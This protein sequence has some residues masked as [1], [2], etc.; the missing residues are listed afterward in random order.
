ML[1]S[2]EIAARL[3][4]VGRRSASVFSVAPAVLV[5]IVEGLLRGGQCRR[6]LLQGVP[7]LLL[8]RR[9]GGQQVGGRADGGIQRLALVRREPV[10]HRLHL[11]DDLAEQ[12]V[13]PA[14][15]RGERRRVT[16]GRLELAHDVLDVLATAR[17]AAAE[18]AQ[19]GRQT[20]R[21]RVVQGLDDVLVVLGEAGLLHRHPLAR[22]QD[23]RR[24]RAGEQVD[25]LLADERELADRRRGVDVQRQRLLLEVHR[26]QGDLAVRVDRRGAGGADHDAADLDLR[27]VGHG[28]D[29]RELGDDHLAVGLRR[30]H[31]RRRRGGP[32]EGHQREEQ[33]VHLAHRPERVRAGRGP[34]GPGHQFSPPSSGCDRAGRRHPNR[35]RAPGPPRCRSRGIGCA[36]SGGTTGVSSTLSG[37]SR[38]G[39]WPYWP[40]AS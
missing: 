5:E 17:D 7:Q 18:R 15:R 23:R 27:L 11:V 20:G 22:L 31:G 8:V 32:E 35:P 2:P 6:E 25:V 34:R 13:L 29:V 39:T 14:Q 36:K 4:A 19:D 10:R 9:G 16:E 33:D 24:R 12:L 37:P 26:H 1:I 40:L 30:G 3:S 38:T 21:R 28:A